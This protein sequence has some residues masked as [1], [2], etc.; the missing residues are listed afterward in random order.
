MNVEAVKTLSKLQLRQEEKY[1]PKMYKDSRGHWTI[2]YG[3]N[4]ETNQIRMTEAEMHLAGDVDDAYAQLMSA[5]GW[6]HGLDDVRCAVLVQLC[7]QLGLEGLLEFHNMLKACQAG[8]WPVAANQL[9][10]SKYGREDCPARAQ[11]YAAMLE[12]GKGPTA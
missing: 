7:F 3:W 9:L 1:V 6:A 4:L 10:D 8:N 11:R 2:G 5:C 12:S